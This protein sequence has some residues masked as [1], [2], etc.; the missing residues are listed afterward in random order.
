M[1]RHDEHDVDGAAGSGIIAVVRVAIVGAGF[2]GIAM[3]MALRRD[4]IDDFTVFE[5]GPELGGV[6]RDNHYPGAACDVP[7]YLYSYSH[8]QR[9]DWSRPCSPQPEI[10]EY[11]RQ[12]AAKHGVTERIRLGTEVTSAA[13]EPA[14]ARWRL[15]TGDG[16]QHEAESLVIACGQLSRPSLPAIA[17]RDEFAGHS[18][19]SAE[20]DHDYDLAGKRVAVVG[21]GASAV[22]FVPPVAERA[23]HVDV[24]QRSA[25]YLLPRTNR[26][27]PRWGRRLLRRVPGLQAL[28]RRYL[29]TVMESTIL[30]FVAVPPLRWLLSAASQAF[31]RHQLRD[32]ELRRRVWPD[33]PIGCKRVLFSSYYLPALQRPD[34]QVVTDA[35]ERVTPAGVVAGGRE[36]QVDCIVWGT[37]FKASE[38]VLPMR[39]TGRDGREL[40]ETWSGGARAHLGITVSGFP[41]MYLLYGPNTNLGVGS[42]IE[43][44]ESQVRYVSG[45]LRASRAAGAALD[46]RPEVQAWSDEQVQSRLRDSIW[47]ACESWYRQDGEGRVVNNWPGFMAE[48]RRLTREFDRGEYV[49]VGASA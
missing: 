13:F 6:W 31:M 3:A 36:R 29:L 7:S 34:V 4:G 45:A 10:L 41:A 20:W 42:I 47:T 12:T 5:R 39:V 9:R 33:Y 8:E 32:R 46:L 28:R 25:P 35:I 22:Q 11:L 14:T 38:F 30:G 18:F 2:S 1:S 44:I 37:G 17:G 16:E 27:Y 40:Q 49:A 21:T 24:Y 43:M 15:T 48:Y 19:H 26:E 23:A